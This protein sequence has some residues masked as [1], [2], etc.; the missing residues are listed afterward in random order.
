MTGSLHDVY[1]W[2]IHSVQIGTVEMPEIVEPEVFY[3]KVS[4]E[5]ANDTKNATGIDVTDYNIMYEGSRARKEFGHHG[6]D[7]EYLRGQTQLTKDNFEDFVKA[8][9][10]PDSIKVVSDNNIPAIDSSNRKM[11]QFEKR[12]DGKEIV[13]TGVSDGRKT[14]YIDSFYET[15]AK[16]KGRLRMS[17]ANISSD[18]RTS[19]TVSGAGP[20]SNVDFSGED[21][22]IPSIKDSGYSFEQLTKDVENGTDTQN[23]I[24]AEKRV[25]EMISKQK[26]SGNSDGCNNLCTQKWSFRDAS[27]GKKSSLRKKRASQR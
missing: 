25:S 13:V 22:N 26:P 12:I 11:I 21:V 8:F 18:T 14:L 2:N 15:K 24:D 7:K 1:I 5:L 27:G 19:K 4:N 17:D 10:N 6:T 3:G 16:E 9:D 20:T 23:P